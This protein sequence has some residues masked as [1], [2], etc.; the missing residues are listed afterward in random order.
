MIDPIIVDTN[1]AILIFKVKRLL[2]LQ[3]MERIRLSLLEQVASRVVI[4]P[5]DIDCE[6]VR[7][8]RNQ[9]KSKK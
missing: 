6:V 9:W 4:L 7:R 5:D 3:D 2:K 8:E 1:D